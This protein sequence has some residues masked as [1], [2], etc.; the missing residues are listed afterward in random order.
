M[1]KGF[2]AV[3]ALAWLG[4]GVLTIGTCAQRARA[5]TL[6]ARSTIFWPSAKYSV[7]GIEVAGSPL[8][9]AMPDGSVIISQEIPGLLLPVVV[10]L[11]VVAADGTAYL[12]VLPDGSPGPLVIYPKDGCRADFDGDGA[13]GLSDV[14]RV[15]GLASQAAACP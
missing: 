6:R 11:R 7:N 9:T 3:L 15:F 5:G 12:A 8:Q 10:S 2:A 13:V 1:T 4:L 14:S